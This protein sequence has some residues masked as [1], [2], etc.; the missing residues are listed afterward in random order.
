M[1]GLTLIATAI[2]V[3]VLNCVHCASITTTT[4]PAS[5]EPAGDL[6]P[7]ISASNGR[8]LTFDRNLVPPGQGSLLVGPYDWE[9]RTKYEYNQT[10]EINTYSYQEG[11]LLTG[12]VIAVMVIVPLIVLV[13]I[14]AAGV[15]VY[16]GC[17]RR[18]VYPSYVSQPG[19]P[20]YPTN[21]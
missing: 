17:A 12:W 13:A 3:A 9:R 20:P 11:T 10:V 14:I 18:K 5:V 2:G 8:L 1:T 4:E 19:P 21:H 6:E 7:R 16:R 15:C